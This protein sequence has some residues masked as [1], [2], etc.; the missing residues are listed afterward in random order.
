M[1]IDASYPAGCRANEP[2]SLRLRRYRF[3]WDQVTTGPGVSHLIERVKYGSARLAHRATSTVG[4]PLPTSPDDVSGRQQLASESYRIK[5]YN[6]RVHL[7]RAESQQ[8]FLAG[9][10]DLGWSGVLS[11]LVIE[12]VPGDHGTINTGIN[13]KI[14]ARKVQ[15]R[16]RR[17]MATGH[18]AARA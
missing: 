13:L 12:H 1:L 7:F 14:L 11:D 2:W 4:V 10:E 15:Q 3:L 18:A 8:E 6:G 5:S 17:P 16:L 9:G